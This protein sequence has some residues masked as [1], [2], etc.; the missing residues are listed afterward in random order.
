MKT[1]L[2]KLKET[3]NQRINNLNEKDYE[4]NVYDCTEFSDELAHRLNDEGWKAERILTVIDCDSKIPTNKTACIQYKGKHDI[5]KITEPVYVE[6]TTGQV[7]SPRN[8]KIY[9]IK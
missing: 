1:P 4:L 8:Y 3:L 7:I 5:V 2:Q 6:A 9:G